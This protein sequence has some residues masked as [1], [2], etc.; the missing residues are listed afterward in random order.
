M[1]RPTP[2]CALSFARLARASLLAG[3]VTGA[4]FACG[5]RARPTAG[6]AVT[7]TPVATPTQAG[8]VAVRVLIVSW[9]GAEGAPAEVTRTRAQAATRAT[10]VAQMVREPGAD[11]V[12]LAQEF[13][14][15][16][17]DTSAR[18]LPLTLVRDDGSPGAESRRR[19]LVATVGPA[20][21]AAVEAEAFA[22][23]VGDASDPLETARGF[24]IVVRAVDPPS[25]PSE[26]GARHLL[27]MYR[28][29]ERAAESITR[30]RDEA[31]ARATEARRRALA[32][33][34]WAALVR[35]YTDEAGAP[36]G[37]D[38]GVFA[39]GAMVPAFERAA[40]ALEIGGISE[41][42]E[43]PFGFHVIQRY[44]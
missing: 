26:I 32:G 43:S 16:P 30:T 2:A 14:D 42:V 33:E 34:D 35:E 6:P 37:G 9:R 7:G 25:R 29:S 23:R 21:M 36:E 41:V 31:R 20:A 1:A 12:N 19:D 15:L 24:V 5:P 11:L 27:V 28:G 17:A 39:H 44:R 4:L 22:L 3:A 40:F 38:L 8:P 18:G 13:A 10:T